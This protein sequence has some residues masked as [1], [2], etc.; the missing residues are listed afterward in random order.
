MVDYIAWCNQVKELPLDL[1]GDLFESV[2]EVRVIRVDKDIRLVLKVIRD[3]TKYISRLK[4]LGEVAY[5][6]FDYHL[7]SQ[8]VTPNTC[9]V[10]PNTLWRQFIPG[11]TGDK[12]RGNL[13]TKKGSPGS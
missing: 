1:K 12:W 9:P 5:N 3:D 2:N 4:I 7:G 11:E 13:Y 10:S 6:L 8:R